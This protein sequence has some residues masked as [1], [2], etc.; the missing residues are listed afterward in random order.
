MCKEA[1]TVKCAFHKQ[2]TEV[3]TFLSHVFVNLLGIL[4]CRRIYKAGRSLQ[5]FLGEGVGE[6]GYC[7]DC[8]A[9]TPKGNIVTTSDSQETI[10]AFESNVMHLNGV[11]ETY[12]IHIICFPRHND[13]TG[14][15]FILGP[16]SN[17]FF[18]LVP[19]S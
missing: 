15:Q 18:Q 10:K 16:P 9:N 2:S 19:I 5:R 4:R 7:F 14:S 17:A 6:V 11:A 3:E 8:E 12:D 1:G 13:I